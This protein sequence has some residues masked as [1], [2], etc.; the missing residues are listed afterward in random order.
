I[1]MAE[2]SK[3]S[4]QWEAALTQTRTRLGFVYGA[5]DAISGAAILERAAAQLPNAAVVG[6]AGLGHYP[7]LERPDEVADALAR[8]LG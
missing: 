1:Y 4:R 6:L 3:L 8:L 2:R 7:Q 5:A